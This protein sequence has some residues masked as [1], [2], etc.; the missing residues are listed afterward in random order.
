MQ[1]FPL[2]RAT[3][4]QVVLL[5]KFVDDTDGKTAE[6]ALTIAASDIKLWKHGGVTE[7][8]KNSGGA[9]HIAAGRYYAT[10][11]AVDSDTVGM[12]EASVDMAGA[13]PVSRK[14]F[15]FPEAV[16]DAMFASGA[17]GYQLP[18]WA[19]AGSTVNLSGTTVKNVTDGVT[20]AANA[21]SA[22]KVAPDAVTAIQLGLATAAAVT[23]LSK[24]AFAAS[25]LVIGTVES[26]TSFLL[27]GGPAND[28]ANVIAAIFD[29]S[30][31]G[32][33]VYAEGSYVGLTGRLTLT[34]ATAITVTSSDTVT[35]I[36][37]SSQSPS[38][39]VTQ[40]A[41]QTVSASGAI[42]FPTSIASAA[43][44]DTVDN[45]L[46]TEIATLTSGVADIQARIPATL[47]GGLMA[48]DVVAISG[49]SSAANNAES[50]FDGTGYAGTNNVIP[51]VT[52]VT[53]GV[54]LADNS[55]TA[56]K[57]ASD[58]VTKIQQG[59]ATATALSVVDDF[60]D[61]EITSMKSVIDKIDTMVEL[62]GAVYRFTTNAVEQSP[63]GG[64]GTADWTTDERTAIRAILGVPVTG[65]TPEVPAAGALKIIDDLID[66]EVTALA[67]AIAAV[68][69]D[70]QDIQARIPAALV[71]GRM[72]VNVGA[73]G[74]GVITAS[75][76]ATGAIDAD[77][78]ATDAVT[79]IADGILSR[80]VSTVESTAAEHTL[81]T[82]ILAAL[83]HSTSGTALTIKR[84][85]GTTTHVVKQLTTNPAAVPITGIS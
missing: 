83:E 38:V 40:I 51:T 9:T 50:F 23:S 84:S 24:N 1:I 6:P 4:S 65:T 64:G 54:S 55:I 43:A 69:T 74:S 47:V 68:E 5:G 56:V 15:V 52:T 48:V 12:M 76:V 19:T 57:V 41:G 81:C 17:V 20:L 21:V 53:N 60:I 31:S 70:T 8:A 42:T 14:F 16:Y 67:S 61:T 27:T 3:A 11:D 75:A 59:L 30:A 85:D 35:L 34:A 7:A 72:D 22:A 26:Q 28:I 71:G 44:L 80:S 2:R 46:D 66:T 18:I 79:E 32:A 25:S 82:V 10:F 45:F 73:M 49:D 13:L 37:S 77:A 33:P 78:L 58:A 39:N 63:S 62:D 29:T 36:Y